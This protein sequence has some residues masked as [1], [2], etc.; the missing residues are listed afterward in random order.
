[1]QSRLLR[2]HGQLAQ[3]DTG[4]LFA[5]SVAQPQHIPQVQVD[6]EASGIAPDIQPL[7]RAAGVTITQEEASHLQELREA[8]VLIRGVARHMPLADTVWAALAATRYTE[9]LCINGKI[10]GIAPCLCC[11]QRCSA[12]TSLLLTMVFLGRRMPCFDHTMQPTSW[13]TSWHCGR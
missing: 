12:S 6:L 4:S 10:E 5:G 2:L 1:M 9:H 7:L 13:R 11:C 3:H 8:I